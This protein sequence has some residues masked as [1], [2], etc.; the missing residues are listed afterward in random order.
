MTEQ[1]LSDLRILDLSQGI[2]GPFAT[3]C[4]SGFGA[5]VIK[6]EPLGRGD[7]ARQMGPFPNDEPHLEK[8][9]LFLYLNT[10]KR[11]LTLN[12]DSDQG[13]AIFRRLA[14]NAD[15]L[16]DDSAPG[17]MERRGLSFE[18]LSKEN[19]RLIVVAI[20]NFGQS[21]PYRDFP[22][23]DLTLAAF[24]GTMANRALHGRQ[25]IRMGGCQ[26]LYMSGL[27]AFI[28]AMGAV[29]LRDTTGEG[30]FVD[31]SLLE[32]TAVNDLAGPTTYSYHGLAR[33]MR[34]FPAGRGRGGMGAYPC[35]DG[36]VDVLPGVGGLKKI[37][38]MLGKPELAEHPWFRDHA[39]RA[40]HAKEFDN[41]FLEP[42]FRER[43]R[44]EVVDRAQ[45]A[46]LPFSYAIDTAEIMED[47]QLAAREYFS[48]VDHP[49]AGPL[50]YPTSSIRLDGE[51]AVTE[52]APLLGE[53]TEE[54][55]TGELEYTKEA[56]QQLRD[57]EVV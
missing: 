51:P 25:P 28:A 46:G 22:A 14:A 26:S 55:L 19:A 5:N 4:F 57:A 20:S 18:T 6:I 44:T 50:P 52:R 53:H 47:P 32:G 8:S 48:S 7:S 36:T 16:V 39:L 40:K 54:I 31:V 24:S 3:K 15:L 49:V 11:S 33:N 9:A 56:L 37:A 1:A 34:G 41:E 42:F 12:L 23:S 30:Q 27:S 2:P 38:V 13:Q 29:L 45:E 43:T 17:T 21:G 35:K 10:R